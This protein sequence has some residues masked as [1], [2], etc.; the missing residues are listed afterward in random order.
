MGLNQLNMV[1]DLLKITR[2]APEQVAV[3]QSIYH[4]EEIGKNKT[5]Q[6]SYNHSKFKKICY[7]SQ[8]V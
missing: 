2:R 3:G 4:L 1:I 6:L 8:I 7:T 5:L